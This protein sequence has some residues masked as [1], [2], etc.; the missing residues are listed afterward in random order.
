MIIKQIST[1]T[2]RTFE[3]PGI[4]GRQKYIKVVTGATAELLDD[5]NAKDAYHELSN[6]VKQNISYELKQ[7]QTKQA[8]RMADKG[9]EIRKRL[10]GE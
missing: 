7:L 8:G 2:S 6:F 3:L 9:G 4:N 1:Q 10:L 5:E